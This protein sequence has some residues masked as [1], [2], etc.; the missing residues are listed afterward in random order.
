MGP[1]SQDSYTN[2]AGSWYK[3]CGCG[4]KSDQLLTLGEDWVPVFIQ[5][6][7]PLTGP[8]SG[9]EYNIRPNSISL[10]IRADDAEELLRIGRAINPV[11]GF[12]GRLARPLPSAE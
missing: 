1:Y 3:G 11:T 6:A 7:G 9:I 12:K 10:D 4:N 2:K 8:K 5:Q